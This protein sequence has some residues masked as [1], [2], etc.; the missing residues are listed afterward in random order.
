VPSLFPAKA[1]VGIGGDE[2]NR[3]RRGVGA[4]L[5]PLFAE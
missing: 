2:S 3:Y 5:I 1:I 4:E